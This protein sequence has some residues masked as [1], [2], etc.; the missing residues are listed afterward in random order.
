MRSSQHPPV[1]CK[2]G[3]PTHRQRPQVV[4]QEMRAAQLLRNPEQQPCRDAQPQ[5]RNTPCRTQCQRTEI[6]RH[7][8]ITGTGVT[9]RKT[10]GRGNAMA[11]FEQPDHRLGAAITAQIP[12]AIHR[13]PRLEQGHQRGRQC[14]RCSQI[15]QRPAQHTQA[16]PAPGNQRQHQHADSGCGAQPFADAVNHATG[17]PVVL[18]QPMP[19]FQPVQRI[20]NPLVATGTHQ[21]RAEHQHAGQR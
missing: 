19:A 10:T 3:S 20:G 1:Q 8:R 5:C 17:E 14:D 11:R 4:R 2:C 21:Q 9:C 12:G 13:R 18:E 15:G 16:W 7:P 6:Q